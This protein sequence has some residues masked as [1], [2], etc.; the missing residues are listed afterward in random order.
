MFVVNGEKLNLKERDNPFVK[1][2]TRKTAF[3]RENRKTWHFRYPSHFGIKANPLDP[4][5]RD[6]YPV[7][8]SFKTLQSF[9]F[10]L[11]G[12]EYVM[13]VQ[14]YTNSKAR[15]KGDI[16]FL[17]RTY[18]FRG[19]K[20][21]NVDNPLNLDEIF[22]LLYV[23]PHCQKLPEYKGQNMNKRTVY[24]TVYDAALELRKEVEEEA[25]ISEVK[26]LIF[27]KRN[28][29]PVEML[30]EIGLGYGLTG[31]SSLSDDEVR[32]TL[33]SHVLSKRDGN[34]KW[35]LI[36][37]F[38]ESPFKD[39]TFKL[40]ALIEKGVEVQVI[41]FKRGPGK[42]KGKWKFAKGEEVFICDVPITSKPGEVLINHLD[43]YPSI[44]EDIETAIKEAEETPAE[45][46]KE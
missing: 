33:S 10:E 14:F 45:E 6:E 2:Y 37:E 44:A 46:P 28:G 16:D 32:K 29:L 41:E 7:E 30:K 17:P 11:D 23:S 24:Y 13:E 25:R 18:Q 5:S 42:T 31:I 15:G 26:S 27:S 1:F 43:R 36:D 21:L 8:C 22:F 39:K 20:I 40:K 3:L 12:Q 4:E 35:R 38:I 34:Y 19:E 9:A